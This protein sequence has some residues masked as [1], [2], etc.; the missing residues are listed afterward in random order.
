MVD[1]EGTQKS[2]LQIVSKVS[3]VVKMVKSIKAWDSALIGRRSRATIK[4]A[5]SAERESDSFLGEGQLTSD[6]F[7]SLKIL[8]GVN[9]AWRYCEVQPH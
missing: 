5:A 9:V 4:L 6:D 1:G 2:G 3:A 7:W 8:V